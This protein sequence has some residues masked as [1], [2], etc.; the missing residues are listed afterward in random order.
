MIEITVKLDDDVV[1]TAV[2]AAWQQAFFKPDDRYRDRTGAPGYAEVVRQ[3]N[4]HVRTLDL[5]DMIAAAAKAHI[6]GVV[7]E[8]VTTALREHAKKKAKEMR[9]DGTL[10]ADKEAS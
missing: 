10:F 7:D 4:E 1:R 5:A 8:V 2:G 9:A 6:A 3:V